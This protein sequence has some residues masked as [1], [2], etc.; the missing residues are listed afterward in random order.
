MSARLL[1][2]TAFGL[3]RGAGKY[4]MEGRLGYFKGKKYHIEPILYLVRNEML[5]LK[6]QGVGWGYN[7]S[8]LIMG[9]TNEHPRDTIGATKVGD[10]DYVSQ[11]KY[12]SY[13]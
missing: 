4:Y 13:E 7:I 12:H 11:L 1:D 6:S 10:T 3:G 5:P 8:Y 2:A 9:L